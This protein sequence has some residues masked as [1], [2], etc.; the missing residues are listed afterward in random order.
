MSA[1]GAGPI[2]VGDVVLPVEFREFEPAFRDYNLRVTHVFKS[3]SI[4]ARTDDGRS[5]W[6][7]QVDGFYRP[8]F[9][10]AA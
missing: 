3:G 8:D 2:S 1:A 5:S 7:G 4:R 10:G 6:V 9:R